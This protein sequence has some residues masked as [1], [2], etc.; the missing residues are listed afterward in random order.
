MARFRI[1]FSAATERFSFFDPLPDVIDRLD[2][3]CF[4]V[5]DSELEAFTCFAPVTRK[6]EREVKLHGMGPGARGRAREREG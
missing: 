4:F 5:A 2:F 3:I 6:H 1:S